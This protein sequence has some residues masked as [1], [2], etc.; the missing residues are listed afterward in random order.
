MLACVDSRYSVVA[1][2]S[3]VAD[4]DDVMV[5]NVDEVS[6]VGKSGI[7]VIFVRWLQSRPVKPG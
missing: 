3:F 1:L 2:L 4:V 5:G 7:I 6:A